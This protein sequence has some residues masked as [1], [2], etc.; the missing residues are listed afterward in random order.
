MLYPEE[1]LFTMIQFLKN[2]LLEQTYSL[3]VHSCSV[4]A[5][6][7]DRILKKVYPDMYLV[8]VQFCSYNKDRLLLPFSFLS[9]I[10]Y[11]F[12][13]HVDPSGRTSRPVQY[14]ERFD[15]HHQEFGADRLYA[16]G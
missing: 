3:W 2:R 6:F 8:L 1:K 10:H 15:Q 5:K 13:K 9:E 4:G 11:V 7:T 16:R 12:C 14:P